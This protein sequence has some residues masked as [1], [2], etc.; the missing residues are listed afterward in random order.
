[1]ND[2]FHTNNYIITTFAAESETRVLTLKQNANETNETIVFKFLDAAA[3]YDDVR[4]GG[5]RN[6]V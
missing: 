1:M 3:R 5:D 2:I 6:C 4:A